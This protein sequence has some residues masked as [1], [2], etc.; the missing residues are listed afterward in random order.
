MV[1]GPNIQ[2]QQP[3]PA[4][5]QRAL[6]ISYRSVAVALGGLVVAAAIGVLVWQFAFTS[7]PAG[8]PGIHLSFPNDWAQVSPAT[9]KGAP[10]NAVVGL[11]RK[12]KRAVLVVVRSGPIP[13]TAATASRLDRQLKAKYSDFKPLRAQY[14]QVQ[15]GKALVVSYERTKQ[16]KHGELDTVTFI[17]A[18][19]ITYVLN[20]TSPVGD[21]RIDRELQGIIGSAKLVPQR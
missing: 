21:A 17:P 11:L 15:A 1:D 20:S 18:G 13:L 2:E 4:P 16:G 6:V 5:R 7:T 12:D 10:P 19:S 9:L 14:V 8:I 3:L